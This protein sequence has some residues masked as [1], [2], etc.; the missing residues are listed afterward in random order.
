VDRDPDGA[1]LVG[2]GAGDRLPDPPGRVRGELV[3]LGVVEL[4]HRPDQPEVPLL[5]QVEEAQAP[6]DVPLGDGHHQPQVRLDEPLLGAQ[7][8]RAQ[9][10]QFGSFS[11][12]EGEAALQL[13]LG[14]QAGLDGLGQLDLFF[15]RQQRDPPDLTQ[16]DADQVAGDRAP[17]VLAVVSRGRGLGVLVSDVN[18][19]N[20]LVREHPHDAV[21][22]MSG[23]LARIDGHSDVTEGHRSVLS[24][25][26]YQISYLV[27]LPRGG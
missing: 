3:P 15:G 4:L 24:G 16:V 27:G 21:E 5:D 13:L 20:A 6:A 17:G 7:A 14:E 18:N 11:P 22:R 19:V 10:G 25:P 8:E 12:A 9:Q 2:D 1:R 26:G 23:K